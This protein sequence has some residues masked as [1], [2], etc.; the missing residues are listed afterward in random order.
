MLI[1]GSLPTFTSCFWPQVW[2]SQIGGDAGAFVPGPEAAGLGGSALESDRT[3]NRTGADRLS[4]R[5]SKQLEP[6]T[7]LPLP[8]AP[9]E[10]HRQ[11]SAWGRRGRTVTLSARFPQRIA[12]ASQTITQQ[13]M[14][15]PVYDCAWQSEGFQ[16][17]APA[18]WLMSLN[19]H[20]LPRVPNANTSIGNFAPIGR[21]CGDVR[22]QRG[23]CHLLCFVSIGF[24]L[25]WAHSQSNPKLVNSFFCL[26]ITR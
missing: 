14:F 24:V 25:C 10:D 8:A 15:G 21:Q 9:T 16:A 12:G 22:W 26:L 7:K 4:K 5:S 23:A 11:F 3:L 1:I 20:V 17:P 2:G 19:K 18:T 6:L 13:V